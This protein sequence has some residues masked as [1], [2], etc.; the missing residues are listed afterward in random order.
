MAFVTDL[1]AGKHPSPLGKKKKKKK[2]LIPTSSPHHYLTVGFYRIKKY[3]S[4]QK[5]WRFSCDFL[6]A[7]IY[8]KSGVRDNTYIGI[9]IDR[10]FTEGDKTGGHFVSTFFKIQQWQTTHLK[11]NRLACGFWNI[12]TFRD[13][14]IITL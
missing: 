14:V 12:K 5:L 10:R 8:R 11:D 2:K 1:G 6:P 4:Y 3:C 7:P 9:Y 13:D